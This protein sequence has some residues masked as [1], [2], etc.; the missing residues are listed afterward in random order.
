MSTPSENK[1]NATIVATS[2][3]NIVAAISPFFGP[4]GV[5]AALSVKALAQIAPDV[6]QSIVDLANRNEVTKDDE[7][8]LDEKI[9]KLKNPDAYFES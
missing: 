6:Y 8:K 2:V 3:A 7:A 9:A 5:V 1:D 4:G